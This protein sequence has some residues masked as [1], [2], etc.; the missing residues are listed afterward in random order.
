MPPGTCGHAAAPAS[1]A[2]GEL[3]SLPLAVLPAC[4]ERLDAPAREL[5]V[6]VCYRGYTTAQAASLLGLPAGTARAR[7]RAGLLA[8]SPAP[9]PPPVAAARTRELI[10]DV[11]RGHR[12][13]CSGVPVFR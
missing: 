8:L 9:A 5:I 7:L 3:G 6:L 13:T 4:L 11:H 2:T 12:L 1:T 10:R